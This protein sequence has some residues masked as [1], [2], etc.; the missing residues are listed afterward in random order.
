MPVINN[1]LLQIITFKQ[2]IIKNETFAQQSVLFYLN[3]NGFDL[4]YFLYC[5]W[6][7]I[8]N[9]FFSKELLSKNDGEYQPLYLRSWGSRK[10][11]NT[12]RSPRTLFSRG[13][14]CTG[15][16]VH[17]SRTLYEKYTSIINILLAHISYKKKENVQIQF[18]KDYEILK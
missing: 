4:I 1:S 18:I 7:L 17:T 3:L 2:W 13:S 10:A 14:W 15:W 12:C 6:P 16:S 5:W 9:M 11:G 8:F